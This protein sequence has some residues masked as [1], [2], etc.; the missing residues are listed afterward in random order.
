MD[1]SIYIFITNKFVAVTNAS[2]QINF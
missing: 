1:I 2:M